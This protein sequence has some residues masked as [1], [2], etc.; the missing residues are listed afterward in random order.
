MMIK[1]LAMI[2]YLYDTAP[3]QRFRIEEWSPYLKK[4]G[5]DIDFLSFC[6]E[7][8]QKILYT[9]RNF[10]KKAVGI[11]RCYVRLFQKII[12]LKG[13]QVIFLSRQ[14]ALFGPPILESIMRLKGIPIVY[15]FDDAVFLAPSYSALG[16]NKILFYLRFPLHRYVKYLCE[17]SSH[18]TVGNDYL[19][20][21]ARRHN[22]NASVIPTTIDT[23]R[24]RVRNNGNKK[25]ITIGWSGSHTTAVIYLLPLKNV[26]LKLKKEVDYEFILICSEFFDMGMP[27][28]F[29]PWRANSEVEDLSRLDIGIM[30]LQDDEWSKGKCGL[31]ILQYMAIGIPVVAS[32]FGV[33]KE[34][35]QD[36]VNGFLAETE[37]DWVEKLLVLIKDAKLRDEMGKKNRKLVEDRYSAELGASKL[38]DVLTGCAVRPL[39]NL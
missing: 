14:A 28:R 23:R 16:V 24:Y 5:I 35:V 27:C 10:F 34:I 26:L 30:P 32:P 6:D 31:K 3:G 22:K 13:Y 29:I 17:I 2:P 25:T 33:N 38:L 18:I 11:F 36:G 9:K 19:C 1:V 8:L 37:D 21:F 15:D 4:N 7:K 20:E 39:R 12:F